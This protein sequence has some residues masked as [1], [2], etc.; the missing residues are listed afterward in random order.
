MESIKMKFNFVSKFHLFSFLLQKKKL[1]LL[2]IILSLIYRLVLFKIITPVVHTDS[3]SFF[4]LNE[5]D[6]VRTIG[7]PFFIE[8]ISNVN[9][10]FSFIKDPIEWICFVQVFF[11]G[12]LNS[13]LLFLI[14]YELTKNPF[15]S[16]ISGIFCNLD[17]F[18]IGFEFQIMSEIL[19]ITLLLLLAYL[20]LKFNFNRFSIV[21]MAGCISVFLILTRP[22][23]L[24]LG[25]LICL[26]TILF[27]L[28]INKTITRKNKIILFIVLFF[29]INLF[30]VTSWSLRNKIK[31]DYFG[32]SSLIPYQLRYYT[33]PLFQENKYSRNNNNLVDKIALIYQEELN[34]TG[35]SSET[36][37]NFIERSKYEL[38]LS[39]AQISNLFLKAQIRLILKYPLQILNQIPGSFNIYYQQYSL[40]WI[41]GNAKRV[42]FKINFLSRLLRFFFKVFKILFSN[43]SILLLLPFIILIL[44]WK[45]TKFIYG[46]GLILIII[47]YNCFV[48]I[49]TTKAGIN[50]LRYRTTAEPFLLLSLTISLYYLIKLLIDNFILKLVRK[51][52]SFPENTK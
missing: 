43:Y 38:G 22:T 52:K 10:I 35:G 44:F 6:T 49:L 40:Y 17:L 50:N 2:F 32:I 23:F 31:Y 47:H 1:F 36:V 29:L 41:A 27:L 3:I 39:E 37:F 12:I 30:G 48:S 9:D 13:C 34:K 45:Q 21:A 25:P 28:F 19:A 5:I 42:L 24:L 26:Y 51:R 20:L 7:Y 4:F 33:N 11:L 46:W 8:L 14:A 16:F 15:L 18:F